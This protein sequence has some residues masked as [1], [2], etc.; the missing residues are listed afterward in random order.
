MS[1]RA[2]LFEALMRHLWSY[3]LRMPATTENFYFGHR[4]DARA[5]VVHAQLLLQQLA[6]EYWVG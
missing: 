4:P 3:W 2:K 5:H 6:D 1:E